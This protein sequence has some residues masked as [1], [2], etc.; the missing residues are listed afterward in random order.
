M[1]L[2]MV[3]TAGLSTLRYCDMTS[4]R[5]LVILGTSLM[6]GVMMPKYMADHPDIIN[7]GKLKWSM[8]DWYHWMQWGRTGNKSSMI[9]LQ[10]RLWGLVQFV[11]TATREKLVKGSFSGVADFC[12]RRYLL[13]VY[14]NIALHRNMLR[15]CTFGPFEIKSFWNSPR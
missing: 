13:N 7:T 15:P 5:N 6:L 8:D 11:L 10:F 3:T 2:G 4:V 14:V 9:G 12:D 1:N